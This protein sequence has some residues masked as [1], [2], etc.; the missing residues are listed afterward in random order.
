MISKNNNCNFD[1]TIYILFLVIESYF[2]IHPWGKIHCNYWSPILFMIQVNATGISVSPVPAAEQ[3]TPLST[4]NWTLS[5]TVQTE[6]LTPTASPMQSNSSSVQDKEP[7]QHNTCIRTAVPSA[8]HSLSTT[9]RICTF[10]ATL[11]LFCLL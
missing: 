7:T 11:S 10:S 9:F 1:T 8:V 6:R 5:P 2:Q 4:R 3:R